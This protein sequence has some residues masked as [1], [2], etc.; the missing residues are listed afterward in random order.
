MSSISDCGGG[1]RSMLSGWREPTM[2]PEAERRG[3]GGLL[4]GFGA[5]RVRR[6]QIVQVIV[7]GFAGRVVRVIF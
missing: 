4:A 1:S 6:R 3:R 5:A 7:G 2:V